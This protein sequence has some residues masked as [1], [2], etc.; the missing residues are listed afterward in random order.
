MKKQKC[1]SCAKKIEKDFNYCPW[2]GAG[3]KNIQKKDMLIIF[4]PLK[5]LLSLR[6]Q[7]RL[8]FL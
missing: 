3:I 6:Y 2:C 1:P 4:K 5:I 7:K 8:K